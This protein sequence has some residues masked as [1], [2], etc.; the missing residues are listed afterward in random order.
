MDEDLKLIDRIRNEDDEAFDELLKRHH[1]MIYKIIYSFSLEN[2]DYA[3]DKDD[4]YQ[5]ASLA[6]YHAAKTFEK[7]RKVLFSS[8][9]YMVIRNRLLNALRIYYRTYEQEKYSIDVYE[10]NN[11]H[12][13]Y[14]SDNPIAYHREQELKENYACFMDKLPETDRNILLL[15]GEDLSYK[16]IARQLKISEKT[17]RQPFKSVKKEVQE[18]SRQVVKGSLFSVDSSIIGKKE[19]ISL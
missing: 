16:E 19:S 13:F 12:S 6:L 2:G 8:Y 5:E 3:V 7:E 15:R 4:L 18:L 11:G 17:D 10:R 14:V 9:A 1:R